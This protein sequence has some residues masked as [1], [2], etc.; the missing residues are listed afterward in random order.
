M[1]RYAVMTDVSVKALRDA[2]SHAHRR[3]DGEAAIALFK[4]ILDEFPSTTEAAEAAF[5]LSAIGE[6]PRRSPARA[7]VEEKSAAGAMLG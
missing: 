5:Y 6:A 1:K 2:A 4:R 3:G 7:S